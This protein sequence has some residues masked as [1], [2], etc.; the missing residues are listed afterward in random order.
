MT[1]FNETRAPTFRNYVVE[2]GIVMP[3]SSK[4]F[5]TFWLLSSFFP[6][7]KQPKNLNF[8]SFLPQIDPLVNTFNERCAPTYRTYVT[9]QGIVIPN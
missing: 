3:T 4:T 2:Q 9:Q 1:T 7:E 5:Q 8:Q 6:L